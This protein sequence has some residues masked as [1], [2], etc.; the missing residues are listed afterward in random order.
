MHR[1]C[2]TY[3][4]TGACIIY[5]AAAL[6]SALPMYTT[7]NMYKLITRHAT[8]TLLYLSVVLLCL[9]MLYQPICMHVHET[10]HTITHALCTIGYQGQQQPQQGQQ[11]SYVLAG[12]LGKYGGGDD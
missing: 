12:L 1:L 5:V 11:E 10:V 8:S 6:Y 7:H 9:F 2:A 3:S 4:Q